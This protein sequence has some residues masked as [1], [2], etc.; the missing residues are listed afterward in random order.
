M[1]FVQKLFLSFALLAC[2]SSVFGQSIAPAQD[3]ITLKAQPGGVS[4]SFLLGVNS[5]GSPLV[6]NISVSTF[7]TGSWLYAS[8]GISGTP[9]SIIIYANASQMAPGIYKG[10][11]LIKAAGATNTPLSVPVTF[12]VGDVENATSLS[13]A[14]QSLVFN[15][16]AGGVAPAFQAIAVTSV[17]A[18]VG[19]AASASTDNGLN[20]LIVS[21]LVATAPSLLNVSI[22]TGGLG[23]GLYR[24]AITLTPSTGGSLEIPVTLNLTSGI[25]I[26]TSATGFQFF[27]QI[28]SF[29]PPYQTFDLTGS[30]GS[31]ISF[32]ITPSTTSGGDW[33]AATPL[34]GGTPRTIAVSASTSGLGPGF[35]KGNLHISAP[36]ASN[37]NID[38][39]VTLTVANGALLTVGSPPAKFVYQIGGTV[40]ATQTIPLGSSAA[41]LNYSVT[42]NTATGGNWLA[43][44][45]SSGTTPQS[46]SIAVNPVNLAGAEYSGTITITAP[47][48][49]NSPVTIPVKLSVNATT[50]L[51]TTVPSVELNY[52]ISGAN[53]VL[54]QFVGVGSTGG[55]VNVTTTVVPAT[56]GANWLRAYPE[57][58]TA[59]A[60][61][62]VGVELLGFV[63]PTSCSGTVVLTPANG[64]AIVQIP[65]TLRVSTTPLF[66][67]TP[68]ALA[69]N[70]AFDGAAAAPQTINI[71][72]TDN[73]NVV[74]SASPSTGTSGSWIRLQTSSA[75]T[76]ATVTVRADPTNL[77]VGSYSGS[78][79]IT[80][81]ALTPGR[82]IPVT[83]KVT[84][85]IT[86]ATS[87]RSLA[88]SQVV[89]GSAPNSQNLTLTTPGAQI[90][91]VTTTSTTNAV[92]WLSAAPNIGTTASTIRVSVNGTGLAPGQYNGSVIITM[93]A[94]GNSPLTVPVTFAITQ[95]QTINTNPTAI[96][97][98]YAAGSANPPTQQVTVTSAGGGPLTVT[99][100]AATTGGATWLTVSPA[101]AATP[102]TFTVSVVPTSLATGS[103]NGTLTFTAAGLP[104]TPA[105]VPV[106]LDV[107]GA[108]SPIVNEVSNAASGKRSAVSPGEI[109][110]IKGQTL[111]PANGVEFKLTPA[112]NVDTVLSGTRLWFDEFAA[113]ILYTSDGQINAIVP[114]EIAGRQTVQISAEYNGIRSAPVTQQVSVAGPGIFTG[115][116]TGSGQG[117]ILNEDNSVNGAATPAAKGSIIQIFATGEGVPKPP[118]QTGSVTDGIH[119]PDGAVVVLIGNSSADVLFAGSAPDAVAG[120]FQVNARVPVNAPSGPVPVVVVVGGVSSQTGVTVAVR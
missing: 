29:F 93:P 30:G 51:T 52:Q 39:P 102:A 120:L 104:G 10:E 109:V 96:S 21:P 20:W 55:S 110:T 87:P 63:T 71:S 38:L 98:T 57:S 118:L 56:C 107:I 86:A 97:Y 31:P 81:P 48:A 75:T 17:P 114:Y 53:Q 119:K 14:P 18:A 47:G 116:A 95:A 60:S 72:T 6:L 76:P 79:S 16:Q 112:G 77:S 62:T 23:P 2:L 49:M 92:N 115:N 88:F 117:S 35:Y 61:I 32:A 85:T 34:M 108:P 65:V 80:S 24:G 33:L 66:N 12:T 99:A 19:F 73:S 8:P 78:I 69:F 59:P 25:N 82:I 89:G 46:L 101:T 103:Y 37:P 50:T 90:S 11:L 28:G 9:A 74:F 1:R 15:G 113:P 3:S 45:P 84:S 7:G 83:L 36:T 41:A 40:P 27:Y 42:V 54:A 4:Q 58:F 100:A 94:A 26:S 13:V 43:V 68:L 5:S 106:R 105:T 111:G 70:A 91:F 44:S 67:I 22:L 64:S